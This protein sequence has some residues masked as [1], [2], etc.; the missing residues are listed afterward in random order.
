MKF[1]LTILLSLIVFISLPNRSESL[2]KDG[3]D[4]SD[5]SG[6]DYESCSNDDG[7]IGGDIGGGHD[8]GPLVL[9]IDG[10]DYNFGEGSVYCS[11]DGAG[12]G[13]GASDT[14]NFDTLTLTTGDG[15][16][17][18]DAGDAGDA[19]SCAVCSSGS[20]DDFS[21]ISVD[22][23]SGNV[24]G[25]NFLL[26][27]F[28]P[29]DDPVTCD[30][31]SGRDPCIYPR[32]CK[33]YPGCNP[34]AGSGCGK[35]MRPD[36]CPVP[37]DCSGKNIIGVGE[38]KFYGVCSMYCSKPS[39]PDG[40]QF[41]FV[42]DLNTCKY[43]WE[44]SVGN[45]DKTKT[46]DRFNVCSPKHKSK[47]P[48]CKQYCNECASGNCEGGL[49]LFNFVKDV[50]G[51]LKKIKLLGE[52]I[53]PDVSCFAS[54]SGQVADLDEWIRNSEQCIHNF[55]N[56]C[57]LLYGNFIKHV[58][59]ILSCIKHSYPAGAVAEM[60]PILSILHG[61]CQAG[62]IAAHLIKCKSLYDL[63]KNTIFNGG[64]IDRNACPNRGY[65][66][67][68]C[69][70]NG[71][72]RSF[73]NITHDCQRVVK[74][75]EGYAYCQICKKCDDK[76]KDYDDNDRPTCSLGSIQECQAPSICQSDT[77]ESC[78]SK[79]TCCTR[80]CN[81]DYSVPDA[82]PTKNNS[83]YY[84]CV[85]YCIEAT[86]NISRTCR[87]IR[88]CEWNGTHVVNPDGS[89]CDYDPPNNDCEFIDDECFCGGIR[90]TRRGL[91]M[92]APLLPSENDNLISDDTS[93]ATS[94]YPTIVI[95]MTMTLI[96]SIFS[97]L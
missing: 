7:A 50:L 72:P 15:G 75:G 79:Q 56:G 73:P 91:C 9:T 55:P 19:G 12:A 97:V 63:C 92:D 84:N 42:R 44:C 94:T 76:D 46:C 24:D 67:A 13:A 65:T 96:F 17:A 18:G 70:Q 52:I 3:G 40:T 86:I 21:L 88:G 45:G 16:G 81:P 27:S 23:S 11:Y 33:T 60:E 43:A 38:N 68:A 66:V 14:G 48:E 77:P 32:T 6:S 35:C 64:P 10:S 5:T 80:S 51:L 58:C 78:A 95:I 83:R 41:T 37:C 26:N 2:I 22:S 49:K 87:G 28:S 34:G 53:P 4:G 36:E 39:C 71:F 59:R 69:D 89:V 1:L 31:N 25:G 57:F 8:F 93:L 74:D 54:V 47:F 61:T 20:E 29:M 62:S 85:G 90:A 30:P 82:Y